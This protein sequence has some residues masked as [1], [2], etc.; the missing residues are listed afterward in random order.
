M[1]TSDNIKISVLMPAYNVEKYVA[2]SINSIINQ[3]FQDFELIIIDDYSTDKT[4]NILQSYIKSLNDKRISLFRNEINLGISRTRNKLIQKARGKYIAWQ[5]A[6]DISLP[7]RLENQFK[8]ME[9][10][11]DVGISGGYL[12]FFNESGTQSVR[13]YAP[14]D[15]TLRKQ[16]FRFSPVSQG[17]AIIRKKVFEETGYF[18]VASPVAEDLAMSFQIGTKYKFAN[19]QE[20][21]L[22]YRQNQN[23]VTFTK[24]QIM[25]LYT[26]LLRYIYSKNPAYKITLSDKI[27]NLIQYLTIFI[28]PTKF[29][30][31][32]FNLLRNK[33]S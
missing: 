8:F 25:E 1:Q 17:T 12:E 20:V 18:P 21:L 5:D 10:H 32:I 26:I 9:S 28:I 30:I 13:K 31:Y 7:Y 4:W 29:K 33:K 19:L 22:K 27:Y 24:L 14:D 3:S 16:I 6:D 23:G 2:E 15:K 11:T